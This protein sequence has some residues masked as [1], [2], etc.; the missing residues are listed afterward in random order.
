MAEFDAVAEAE[1]LKRQTKAIRKPSYKA[2]KSRLDRFTSELLELHR[3]GCSVAELQRW[4]REK[5]IKVAHSTVARW[6]AKHG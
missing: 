2:R 5:R 1:R 4:L 3:S 6:L